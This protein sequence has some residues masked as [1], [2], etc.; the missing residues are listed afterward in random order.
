MESAKPDIFFSYCWSNSHQA[1]EIGQ[2]SELT[3]SQWNDPRQIA[4]RL[5]KATGSVTWIDIKRLESAADGMGMVRAQIQ[6]RVSAGIVTLRFAFSSIR[7]Q[8]PSTTA[9]LWWRA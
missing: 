3:G 7:S 2:I 9:K 4:E 8:P 1:K 6:S 5:A